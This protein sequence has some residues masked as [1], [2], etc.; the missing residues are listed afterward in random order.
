[1]VDKCLLFDKEIGKGHE[2][3]QTVRSRD[4]GSN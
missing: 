4:G 2:D 3:I 1:M